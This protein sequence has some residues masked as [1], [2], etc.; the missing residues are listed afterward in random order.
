MATVKNYHVLSKL[1]CYL[2]FPELREVLSLKNKVKHPAVKSKLSSMKT[3]LV[4]SEFYE[5][6]ETEI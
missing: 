1:V 5:R 2:N 3:T 6:L 4:K